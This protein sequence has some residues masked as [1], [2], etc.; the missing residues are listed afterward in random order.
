MLSEPPLA[1]RE[2]ESRV[3]DEALKKAIAGS[4]SLYLISGEAGIGKTRLSKEFEKRAASN[5]CRI[6][7]G[8][9]VP[10][11]PIPYLVFL[12][13]LKGLSNE[14]EQR[15]DL[16]RTSR[17][18][19][20]AKRAAP[21]LVDAI[22][23]VGGTTKALATLFKEYQ[24]EGGDSR[25]ENLLFGTLELL[26]TE[27]GKAPLIV[28]L[29]DLQW[30]DS[31][32]I[33]MLH[34]LARNVRGLPILLLGTYRTEEVLSVEKD[35][36]PFLDSLQ[37][38]N[39][40][41]IVDEVNLQPLAENDLQQVVSGMLQMP[42]E[43]AAM[44]HICKESGGS[45][46]FAV[47]IVRLLASEGRLVQ[48]DGTLVMSGGDA[49]SIPRTIQQVISRRMDKLSNEQR[50]ILECAS[51]I[52]E[53]FDP[54]LISQSIGIDNLHLLDELDIIN[55]GFQLVNWDEGSYKFT[56]GRIRDVATI[57]SLSQND[58][59]YTEDWEVP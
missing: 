21:D 1:G 33:G 54:C 17:L 5:G 13:A 30:A 28:R 12:E 29:D 8:N 43:K 55:K 9:C 57:L 22:P 27:S 44:E 56:H 25:S 31:A 46:L 2:V 16:S 23:V 6:L 51:V 24:G 10:A 4:G 47:E 3:L 15:T 42:V 48:K 58:W 20:A 36:H 39:R 45:P 32:S 50:R 34:F 14:A 53:R 19:S 59:N 11:A 38:M 52:G 7:V 35:V 37:V 41:G 26:K 40:E 49:I 18:K